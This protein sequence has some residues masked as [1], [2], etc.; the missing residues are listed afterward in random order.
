MV[1]Y[2]HYFHIHISSASIADRDQYE[3]TG[4]LA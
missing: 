2:D 3:G 1:I 4:G